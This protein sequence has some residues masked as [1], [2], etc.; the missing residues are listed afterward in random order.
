MICKLCWSRD[1]AHYH[2]IKAVCR[3]PSPAVFKKKYFVKKYT[4][5]TI[6][7]TTKRGRGG[8]GGGGSSGCETVSMTNT[9]IMYSHL[10]LVYLY[11]MNMFSVF[12]Q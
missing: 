5:T 8:G 6:T 10:F 3:F 7:T 11:N 4:T 2:S 12:V 1:S 9:Y